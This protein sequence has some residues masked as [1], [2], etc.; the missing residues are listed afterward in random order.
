MK[1]FKNLKLKVTRM[2]SSNM[3]THF[4]I[5]SGAVCTAN[6]APLDFS[7]VTFQIMFFQSC[8]LVAIVS[9]P[10][11]AAFITNYA[12]IALVFIRVNPLLND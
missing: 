4:N 9:N 7:W 12:L 8:I 1:C 5:T 11:M 2:L 6:I 10:F 3:P